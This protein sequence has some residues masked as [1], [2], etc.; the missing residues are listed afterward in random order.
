[1][2]AQCGGVNWTGSTTCCSG[3]TCTSQNQYYSQCLPIPGSSTSSSSTAQASVTTTNNDGRQ[4]GVT[5][6]YWDCCKAS[7]G[8]PGKAIFSNPVETCTINGI[9]QI[10]VNAQSG[11]NGGPAYMCNN[12]QPWNVSDNLSYGYAAA[13]IL[14]KDSIFIINEIR[15]CIYYYRV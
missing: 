6:R 3:S 13:N 2:Y 1:M 14:V 11:C 7:C 8:W 12:Q 15:I 10:D 5:T 9:T 4:S